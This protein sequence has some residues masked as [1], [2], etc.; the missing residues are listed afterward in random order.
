[1]HGIVEERSSSKP[2]AEVLLRCS[3][4]QAETCAT[5]PKTKVTQNMISRDYTKEVGIPSQ[6]K[7][8]PRPVA[9]AV[10]AVVAV[11]ISFGVAGV[12]E[13]A[14]AHEAAEKAAATPASTAVVPGIPAAESAAAK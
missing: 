6:K 3:A 2:G 4:F 1:M 8:L 10:L 9:Y 5:T 11:G 7:N 12:V 13:K 14:R